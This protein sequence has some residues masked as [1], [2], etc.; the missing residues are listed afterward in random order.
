MHKHRLEVQNY[1]HG[2]NVIIEVILDRHNLIL[3]RA[4]TQKHS[5]ECSQHQSPNFRPFTSQ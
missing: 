3:Q 1:K 5:V 4:T 2:D